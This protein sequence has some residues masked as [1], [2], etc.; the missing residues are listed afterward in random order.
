LQSALEAAQT[1]QEQEEIRRQ[2]KRL[3]DEEEQILRDADEL[4]NRMQQPANQQRMAE[5]QK[6]LD[7][8]RSNVRRASEALAAGQA[9]QAAAAGSRAEKQLSDLRE[10][11]RKQAAG[12]FQDEMREMREESKELLEREQELG[13]QMA[14]REK[15]Q[16]LSLR[17]QS[18]R[19]LLSEKFGEQRQRLDKLVDEMRKTVE[20]AESTEPLLSKQLYDTIRQTHQERTGEALD[21]TRQLLERGFVDEANKAEESARAGVARLH[22]GIERAAQSVLGD[23]NEALR[24]ARDAVDRLAQALDDEIDRA[25]GKPTESGEP[26]KSGERKAESG[27]QPGQTPGK[28]E[29]R[30]GSG[31]QGKEGQGKQGQGKDGKGKDGEGKTPGDGKSDQPGG[32]PG[33]AGSGE[34]AA[35]GGEQQPGGNSQQPSGQEPDGK[36]EGQQ[37]GG[38]QSGAGGGQQ[39]AGSGQQQAGGGQ[40]DGNTPNGSRQGNPNGGGGFR[41]LLDRVGGFNSGPLT[42]GEFR[43]FADGLRDVEEMLNDPQLRA[44]AARIRDR[45]SAV[46]AEFKRHSKEPNWDLVRETISKPLTELRQHLAEELLKQQSKD[47]LVPLDRDPV[48][49]KYSEQVRRYYERLGSG[50]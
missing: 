47:A 1:P 27:K 22:E 50:R 42:G 21:V 48:P 29:Q 46:R 13:R 23:E 10:Q 7:Q 15:P 39:P 4:R 41:N 24:R 5:A 12:R 32:S 9:S 11:F 45:A 31:E 26:G 36:G 38:K 8:T 34:P 37:S 3:R 25:S 30:P 49:P 17:P 2:L 20:E 16:E 33:K 14:E 44:E 6:Q 43:Q 19:E 35:G 18:S 40:T 28:G